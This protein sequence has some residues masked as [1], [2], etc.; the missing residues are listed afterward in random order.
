MPCCRVAL[1]LLFECCMDLC[2]ASVTSVAALCCGA[3]GIVSVVPSGEKVTLAVLLSCGSFLF[4]PLASS[5]RG[6]LRRETFWVLSCWLCLLVLV[7]IIVCRSNFFL[8][9][10]LPASKRGLVV[11]RGV[12]DDVGG[13]G[14]CVWDGISWS[15][16]W[17]KALILCLRVPWPSRGLACCGPLT[18]GATMC[19][20]IFDGLGVSCAGVI[21]ELRLVMSDSPCG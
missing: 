12:G 4:F 2:C 11:A 18:S 16:V 9:R 1:L 13:E 5:L 20:T 21:V 15:L 17:S 8:P 7:V 3:D 19:A 10:C 14:V 6:F